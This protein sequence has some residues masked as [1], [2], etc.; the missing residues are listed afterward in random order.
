MRLVI[1]IL[2]MALVSTIV[3]T[4]I[5]VVLTR[6][7][8]ERDQSTILRNTA[9]RMALNLR[10][11]LSARA[12][13]VEF[14]AELPILEDGE[15]SAEQIRELL[16]Y[17]K[18]AYPHYAWVGLVDQKGSILQ[19]ADN[20]LVD[21]SVSERAWFTE[22]MKGTYF[23]DAHEAVLL[24]KL[25]APQNDSSM[26]LRLV[27]ISAPIKDDQGRVKYVIGTHLSLEWAH[28]V[29][30]DMLVQ[31]NDPDVEILVLNYEGSLI[32]D[33][34]FHANLEQED[35][36]T[37]FKRKLNDQSSIRSEQLE[38]PDGKTYLTVAIH[39]DEPQNSPT[40]GWT[41]VA[42][43][44][45]EAVYEPAGAL[46]RQII[47]GSVIIF[48][49]FTLLIWISV[50]R[51]LKPLEEVAL[52]ADR[53]RESEAH[54][55]IPEMEGGSEVARFSR[56][57]TKLVNDLTHKNQ[58][59][60]LADRMFFDNSLAI[61]VTDEQ[62]RI[63]RVNKAFTKFT[64]FTEEEAVGNK[65]SMLSSGRHPKEF[66]DNLNI[67]LREHG[68]W[69]GEIWNKHKS[70][71]IYPEYLTIIA[72]ID[73]QG[74]VNNYIAMFEDITE[75]KNRDK[76]IERLRNFDPLTRLP[77]RESGIRAVEK[78]I[79]EA[80]SE[81]TE[82]SLI[83]VD[84]SGFKSINEVHGH[85]Q[86]DNLI[87]QV[88]RRLNSVAMLN[89]YMARW[90]G[91][92]FLI[93]ARNCNQERAKDII[94]RLLNA[95]STPFYTQEDEQHLSI[96]CGVAIY[97]RDADDVATLLRFADIA[98][99]E[100]KKRR[101][102]PALFYSSDM[103]DSI[104][105]HME[106]E[107]ALRYSVE[108]NFAG[109][110]L[111]YQP[112]YSADT[113]EIKGFEALIRWQMGD[114]GPISPDIFIP[115]AEGNGLIEPIGDWVLGQAC[116]TLKELN[117]EQSQPLS[118]SVNVSGVQLQTP[119]YLKR[120]RAMVDEIGISRENIIVEVTETA[121]MA[122]D[123]NANEVL[124]AIRAAGFGVSIDDFGTGY[125]S[126]DYIQ[127]FRPTEIKVDR[128]FVQKMLTDEHC[129]NIVKFTLNLA[130]SMK[131]E[132]V[133]EGVETQEQLDALKSMGKV[134]A[135]GYLLERPL[136]LDQLRELMSDA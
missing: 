111:F 22:G 97:P 117:A 72:L 47:L 108:H 17:I 16:S 116:R 9:A 133:A 107:N 30:T 73:E 6:A 82:V 130:E 99:L 50:K 65:P 112:Q 129:L 118:M 132:V 100:S 105:R 106:I 59:L 37:F 66:Y 128:V 134:I 135:Q 18:E 131:L 27:D 1:L 79:Q 38:W 4:E 58:E 125:A 45:L 31:L 127:R 64:G 90:G 35:I 70:G 96:H 49:A 24:A 56:S 77:N 26:P 19:D 60:I 57:L 87:K 89:G 120:L 68:S 63:V 48:A 91:D 123:T 28:E 13:E 15:L 8:V 122:T 23:G 121:F 92:E 76:N 46:A 81:E 32:L 7:Q 119:G 86:G 52:L 34:D 43:K 29:Q 33:S 11:D 80:A 78:T 101:S 5:S 36:E 124:S 41:I 25:L 61:M 74:V 98:L 136:P 71:R 115:L 69:R 14:F 93:C 54:A 67:A 10:D 113:L 44:P 75:Q 85:E 20:L 94:E 39:P 55:Q 110:D 21:A 102:V 42:R 104:V 3:L 95:M 40:L 51:S 103:N 12:A 126:L 109:F 114:K 88:A 53:I 83:F 2:G 62:R 84:I